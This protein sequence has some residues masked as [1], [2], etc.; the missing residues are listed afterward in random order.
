MIYESEK[1]FLTTENTKTTEKENG[2][3]F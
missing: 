3:Y 1:R 2:R